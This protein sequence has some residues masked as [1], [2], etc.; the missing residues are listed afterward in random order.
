[1]L[2]LL[3]ALGNDGF[4]GELT[5]ETLS[6][7]PVLALLGKDSDVDGVCSPLSACL[8]SGFSRLLSREVGSSDDCDIVPAFGKRLDVDDNDTPLLGDAA[9]K[10]GLGIFDGNCS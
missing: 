4:R 7:E 5:L 2:L 8:P 10:D 9:A 3:P 6:K 1:V